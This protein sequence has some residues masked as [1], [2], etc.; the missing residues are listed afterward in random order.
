M[1]SAS[2][3]LPSAPR[4]LQDPRSLN[5]RCPRT[6]L[7]GSNGSFPQIF[8]TM[9]CEVSVLD[10]VASSQGGITVPTSRKV[11]LEAQP[12]LQSISL[13]LLIQSPF[14]LSTLFPCSAIQIQVSSESSVPCN[15]QWLGQGRTFAGPAPLLSAISD[16]R[17]S[18]LLRLLYEPSSG[19]NF[20]IAL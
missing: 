15:P 13:L 2:H 5:I 9:V 14:S 16:P 3:S 18:L 1:P 11:F 20:N 19:T 6:F 17:L 8:L 12:S 10:N 7:S 4:C